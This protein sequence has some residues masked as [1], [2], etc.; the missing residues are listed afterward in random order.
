MTPRRADMIRRIGAAAILSLFTLALAAFVPI[1]EAA[2]TEV[3]SVSGEV[4]TNWTEP[5]AP[6]DLH[7][8]EVM[9]V[10]DPESALAVAVENRGQMPGDAALEVWSSV[11]TPDGAI[12]GSAVS[13]VGPGETSLV[14]VAVDAGGT[15]EVALSVG[16]S[17]IG[18]TPAIEVPADVCTPATDAEPTTTTTE[19]PTTTTTEAPTTTT[20]AAPTTSTTTSIST[21]STSTSTTTTPPTSVTTSTSTSTTTTLPSSTS[22]TTTTLPG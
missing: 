4:A 18:W 9:A 3:L 17:A 22:T 7:L 21:T 15:Y 16:G 10:C 5:P 20:S 13:S 8:G 12:V 11:G 1:G 6:A 14:V 2:W 19:A